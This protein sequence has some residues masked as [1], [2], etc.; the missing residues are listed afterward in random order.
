MDGILFTLSRW[1]LAGQITVRNIVPM[2]FPILFAF[3]QQHGSWGQNLLL[4]TSVLITKLLF[5]PFSIFSHFSRM[6]EKSWKILRGLQSCRVR[7]TNDNS[8]LEIDS[9]PVL[10]DI[11][12]IKHVKLHK[13]RMKFNHTDT[14]III[15]L[16]CNV[17]LSSHWPGHAV[18]G[19]L[20]YNTQLFWHRT[21]VFAVS[22]KRPLHL[23]IYITLADPGGWGRKGRSPP[24]LKKREERKKGKGKERKIL[25]PVCSSRLPWARG[26]PI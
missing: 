19:S 3:L 21:S 22:S 24:P 8:A 11:R 16:L 13:S 10:E 6:I 23:V 15:A 25:S 7:V 9:I 2:I 14:L 5:N 20:W 4:C 18:Q 17:P 12:L 26:T 1:R